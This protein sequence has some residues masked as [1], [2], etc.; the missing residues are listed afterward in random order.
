MSQPALLLAG[1]DL[2]QPVLTYVVDDA[3]EARRLAELAGEFCLFGL[4]ICLEDESLWT[5]DA[6]YRVEDAAPEAPANDAKPGFTFPDLNR[7]GVHIDPTAP[8]KFI[9]ALDWMMVLVAAQVAALWGAGMGLAELSIGGAAAFLAAAI[10]LKA[11][12]WLTESYR[13][14]VA[15]IRAE[16]GI[17]GLALGTILG[18]GVATFFAPDARSSAALSAVLPVA[19]ML[20]AGMHAAL[21]VW[22]RAAHAKGVFSETIV[23]VGATEAAERM[24]KRAAK[25]GEARVVAIVD[26]RLSRVGPIHGDAPVG[27]NL[28]DLLKWEGLPHIDRIVITVTQ[29]AEGRVN[30]IIKRLRVAPNRVDLLLDYQ[31]LNVR[32]KRIDRLTG[33]AVACVS[34]RPR[35]HRRALVKRAQD[36]VIGAGLLAL[37]ALPMLAIAIAIKC[38]SRGPVLYRQRRHGFNNRVITV[39]KF[40]SMQHQPNAALKQVEHNDPRVTKIGAYLRRTSLDELP[41]LINV[42]RGEMSLVGPRPH[43]IGMKADERELTQIV[44]EYAHRHCVKP[45]ITGWAQVNGSRGPVESPAAVRRRV[46]L[47]LEYVSR[48]SL[49]LDL[50]ILVRSAPALLGDYEAVR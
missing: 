44:A 48:A 36:I 35:N 3:T 17:G 33:S 1:A 11:G 39:L 13:L 40:R 43:A 27:G 8:V 26:D 37:F 30:D 46:K 25:T 47:D 9:Q 41:Q 16:R 42:L 50:E 12:L 6:A 28:D 31:T 5:A 4:N 7:R 21:A 19:A 29:K 34:G 2:D 45:G 22:I 20:L 10:S 15:R 24:A 14:S 23:L 49:W 18:L 32:G 38:D